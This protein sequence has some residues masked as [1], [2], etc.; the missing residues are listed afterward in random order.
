MSA[1]LDLAVIGGTGLYQF[2]G[3]EVV[4][5]RAIDT[6]FGKPSDDLV[7]GRLGA[8]R[9]GFLARHGA[10]HKHA[11]HRVNYRANVWAVR[12][13]GAKRVVAVNAVGGITREMGPRVIAVPHQL[14]DYTQ[15]RISSYCDTDTATEVTHIDFTEPF[16]EPLR[17]ALLAAA[18][19]SG[20]DVVPHGVLA[21]T[22]G[23]RLETTAEVVRLARDGCDLVGMTTM[24]EAA[25]A[26]ELELDYATLCMV[27]NW[28]AGCSEAGVGVHAPPITMDEI[29]GH[30]KSATA[31]LPAIIGALLAA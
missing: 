1:T 6:P 21:V 31:R 23:P 25:L 22:Q 3:L 4:E 29:F 18:R 28:A 24:P 15:G 5:R 26:R 13:A 30:L 8:A 20:T 16:H 2:P 7:I 12:E 10:G 11:P 9:V 27:A 14:I 17:A 19:A